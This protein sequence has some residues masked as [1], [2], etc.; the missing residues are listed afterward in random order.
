M[1]TPKGYKTTISITAENLEKAKNAGV[2]YLG[3]WYDGEI[4]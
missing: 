3:I 1:P 4:I 2:Q